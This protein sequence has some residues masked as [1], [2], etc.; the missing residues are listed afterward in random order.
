MATE[1]AKGA[2]FT[3]GLGHCGGCHP[4]R[5]IFL[6]VRAA[7]VADGPAYLSGAVIENYF[8]PS[9][10][11]DG[12]GTLGE[13]SADDVSQFLLTGGNTRGI[14]FGSMSDVITHSTQFMTPEDAVAMAKYLKTLGVANAA[15]QAPFVSDASNP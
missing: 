11:S 3:E 9:L 14:A 5:G 1:G 7:T 12:P 8:A 10:R 13:W 2:Y 6:E 15:A 4:P